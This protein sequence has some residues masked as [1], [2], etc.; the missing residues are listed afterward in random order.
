MCMERRNKEEEEIRLAELEVKITNLESLVITM[1]RLLINKEIYSID[2]AVNTYTEVKESEDCCPDKE[3]NK[4]TL[5][6]EI[7]EVK[8]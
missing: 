3:I 8:G 5:E 6:G 1:S 7:V 4:L 2:E